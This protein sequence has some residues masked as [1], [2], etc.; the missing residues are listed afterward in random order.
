MLGRH[1]EDLAWPPILSYPL[2]VVCFLDSVKF[3]SITCLALHGAILWE[4]L[5]LQ[6]SAMATA[7]WSVQMMPSLKL[8]SP[9]GPFPAVFNYTKGCFILSSPLQVRPLSSLF[10]RKI[11]SKPELVSDLF[12]EISFVQIHP[13]FLPRCKSS[14]HIIICFHA[15]LS[16]SQQLP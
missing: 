14:T 2:A 9:E 12:V 11:P 6:R 1:S 16:R 15:S 4:A 7:E 5:P 3:L 13:T 8:C 10:S